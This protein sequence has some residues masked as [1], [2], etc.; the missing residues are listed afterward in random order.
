M[1]QSKDTL[2][3]QAT[4]NLQTE[5]KPVGIQAVTAATLCSSAAASKP[6]N[7]RFAFNKK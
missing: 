5:Y 3:T 1:P 6:S 4:A 7:N 2:T